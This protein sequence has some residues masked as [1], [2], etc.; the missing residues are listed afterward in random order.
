MVPPLAVF[1]YINKAAADGVVA[2]LDG[3]EIGDNKLQVTRVP[4]HAAAL[5]LQDT[6]VSMSSSSKP[7][8]PTEPRDATMDMPPTTVLRLSNM[9][10]ADDL[11]D[12]EL[13][14]EVR[15]YVDTTIDVS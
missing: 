2:G 4:L 7:P 8:P 3:L 14:M 11:K 1:E 15:S 12:D 10:T 6:K 13:Y 5:L 9:T